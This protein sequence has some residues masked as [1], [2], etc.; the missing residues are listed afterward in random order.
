[1]RSF[2]TCDLS[3]TK[4][5]SARLHRCSVEAVLLVGA[6][7]KDA[8]CVNT[9]FARSNFANATLKT[10]VVDGANFTNA[11]LTDADM[12][13]AKMS[14]CVLH[15][16]DVSRAKLSG[17]DLSKVDILNTQRATK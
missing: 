15:G 6:D 5:S 9:S 11:V 3:N 1:M 2:D 4:F 10:A 8:H 13:K 17:V 7:F 12:R 16:A 14:G